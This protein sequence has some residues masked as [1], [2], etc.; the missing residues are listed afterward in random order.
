MVVSL[1]DLKFDYEKH[2]EKFFHKHEDIR[3]AFRNAVLKIINR[4]NAAQV[5]TKPLQGI[6]KG[7][8]RIAI[9]SYRV[10]YQISTL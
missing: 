7:Y 1:D 9:G 2:A 3:E 6:L 8:S 10:I 4:D 5:N